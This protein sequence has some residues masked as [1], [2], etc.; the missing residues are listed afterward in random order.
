MADY[1]PCGEKKYVLTV[2]ETCGSDHLGTVS[3]PCS[4]TTF[5]DLHDV[6]KPVSLLEGTGKKEC[7]VKC[8]QRYG[9]GG[10]N[11]EVLHN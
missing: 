9:W 11:R 6:K 5:G 10:G 2:G 1:E 7:K 4:N 3:F 8:L